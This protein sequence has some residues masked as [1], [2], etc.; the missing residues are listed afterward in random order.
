[1]LRLLSPYE[2]QRRCGGVIACAAT[3]G[4][5][6]V[7]ATKTM[8]LVVAAACWCAPAAAEAFTF[9]V[10]PGWVDL[11]PGAPDANFE[12]LPPALVSSARSGTY[13]AV[14]I[15]LRPTDGDPANFNAVVRPGAQRVTEEAV[16]YF[17][18]GLPREL[19]RVNPLATSR[20]L[21]HRVVTVGDVHFGRVVMETSVV[22]GGAMRQLVYVIPGEGQTAVVTYSC[23]PA[24]Y[25]RYEP[26]FDAAARATLGAVEPSAPESALER[27][28]RRGAVGGILGAL[29]GVVVWLSKKGRSR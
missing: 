1:M 4:E 16:A 21:E 20:A 11:S 18:D 12:G 5:R 19:T 14:A 23:P 22:L 25:E 27:I 17:A 8:V 6:R 15:D 13:A 3:K 26:I 10:P 2:V 28:L 7:M 24:Q 9:R 29:G